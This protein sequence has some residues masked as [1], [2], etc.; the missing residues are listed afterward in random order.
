MDLFLKKVLKGRAY[1]KYP[2]TQEGSSRKYFRVKTDQ[3]SYIL[4]HSPAHQK[5]KFLEKHALFSQINLNVPRLYFPD[6]KSGFLL[7]EDLGDQS[8]EK[9]VKANSTFPFSS[10]IQALDQIISLQ[11]HSEHALFPRF[12]GFFKEMLLTEKYL[13]KSFFKFPPE[14]FLRKKYL[15][16]WQDICEK[17]K[18]FPL[19]PAHRDCHSRNLFLKD[20]NVYLIDFQDA[21]LFPRFYDVVSLLY[22]VYVV[23]KIK[24]P[25]REKLLKYFHH[26]GEALKKEVLITALQ[27][28]FK[29]S[30][31]FAGFYVLKGQKTH[32]KYIQPALKELERL[33]KGGEVYYPGFLELIQKLLNLE[34]KKRAFSGT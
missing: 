31:S 16:E 5:K 13:V 9:E 25:V 12:Q 29:A 8:L 19:K 15:K 14:K 17:L 27:R 22:D 34:A 2:L 24:D 33:L 23:D 28:L 3:N 18:S 26:P 1:K 7:L 21:G 6:L 32:L 11:K 10:Y 4:A 20:Q 30:G